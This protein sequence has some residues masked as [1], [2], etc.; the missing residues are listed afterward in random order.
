MRVREI[1]ARMCFSQGQVKGNL[2]TLRNY[3]L[4]GR[5]IGQEVLMR[6]DTLGEG[7]ECNVAVALTEESY[8]TNLMS[9]K[10][11]WDSEPA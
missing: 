7:I 2:L 1:S 6:F 9:V 8:S 10:G 5:L 11:P 3:S 4:D